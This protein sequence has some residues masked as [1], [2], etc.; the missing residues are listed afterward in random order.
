MIV[1]SPSLMEKFVAQARIAVA[2]HRLGYSRMAELQFD[3]NVLV[4]LMDQLGEL[5]DELDAIPPHDRV[6]EPK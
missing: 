5:L 4:R 1:T 3:P 2:Y 6:G